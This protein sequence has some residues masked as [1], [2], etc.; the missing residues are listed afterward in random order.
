MAGHRG[1]LDS[2]TFHLLWRARE[3]ELTRAEAEDLLAT[4]VDQADAGG[5][6]PELFGHVV[7][8]VRRYLVS[9]WAPAPPSSADAAPRASS[10]DQAFGLV[11]ANA[12]RPLRPE[13]ETTAIGADIA[14][15]VLHELLATGRSVQEACAAVSD[16]RRARKA[17]PWGRS[18]IEHYWAANKVMAVALLRHWNAEHWTKT[19]L[20]MLAEIYADVPGVVLAGET[21]FQDRHDPDRH[22]DETEPARRRRRR[23]PS[24]H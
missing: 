21:P 23:K 7:E 1:P 19:E 10:L 20:D 13:H 16:D 12:H 11:R 18:Q 6:A 3:G 2:E 17:K 8:C 22:P 24:A 15:E 9:Q 14:A 4:F 5:V